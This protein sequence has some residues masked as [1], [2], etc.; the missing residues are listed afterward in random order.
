MLC[1]MKNTITGCTMSASN[2][3]INTYHIQMVSHRL[4]KNNACKK[5]LYILTI[6]F[7]RH[8]NTYSLYCNNNCK[9]RQNYNIHSVLAKMAIGYLIALYEK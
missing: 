3:Q 5:I 8:L 4:Q 7:L 6:S 9:S 1:Y 2:R